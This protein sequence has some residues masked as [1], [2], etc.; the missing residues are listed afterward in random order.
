MV[1]K[2]IIGTEMGGSTMV[3]ERGKIM[4]FARAILDENPAYFSEDPAVPLTYTMASAHWPAPTGGGGSKLASL[5]LNLLK[6][7]H[8]GQEYEYLG[9]IKA[10]DTLTSRSRI[11]DVY[12]KDGKAGGKMVFVVSENTFTN[13]RGEDVLLARTILVQTEKAAS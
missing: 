6:I 10:G 13:Q 11:S 3:V 12:E 1:D 9:E 4:E 5:G 7:L 8:A 2:S